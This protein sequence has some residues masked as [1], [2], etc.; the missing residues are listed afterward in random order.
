MEFENPLV[1]AGLVMYRFGKKG[2]E[3]F[4]VHPG[5]PYFRGKE[6]GYYGIP[7]GVVDEKEDL[8]DA[9]IREFEEET[10]IEVDK[11]KKFIELGTVIKKSGK[12]I[13]AWAFEGEFNGKVVSNTCITEWPPNSRKRIEIPEIDKGRFFTFDEAREMMNDRQLD[14]FVRLREKLNIH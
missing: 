7:K 5:G 10:G 14:F 3:V 4:L 6:K 8:F 9:A 11:N 13:Y 1:S 12:Y 2:L